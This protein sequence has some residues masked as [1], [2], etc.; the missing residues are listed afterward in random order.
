MKRARERASESEREIER[1][2]ER[3]R[4][5]A[6]EYVCECVSRVCTPRKYRKY[7]SRQTSA[8]S[9]SYTRSLLPHIRSLLSVCTPRKYTSS[10]SARSSSVTSASCPASRADLRHASVKRDLVKG[11]KRPSIGVKEIYYNRQTSASSASYTRSLLPHIRS[12]LTHR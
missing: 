6:T 12:L 9:A 1:E 7:T 3:A 11:Q 10:S 5:R 8:S 4:A 2:R